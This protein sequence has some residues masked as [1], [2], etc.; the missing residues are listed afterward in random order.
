MNW[1]SC[2]IQRYGNLKILS[3]SKAINA[4]SISRHKSYLRIIKLKSIK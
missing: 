4:E 3:T 2:S 1:V